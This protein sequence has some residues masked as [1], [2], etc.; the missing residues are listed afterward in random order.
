MK[1]LTMAKS[2]FKWKG[3]KMNKIKL[4]ALVGKSGAGK[5][6]VATELVKRADYYKVVSSTTRPPRVGEEDGVD[7]H[8][9]TKEEFA[10]GGFAESAKFNNWYYGTR[11]TDL[12]AN[13]INVGVFNPSGIYQLWE[14]Q[15]YIDLTVIYIVAEDKIRLKRQ[16]EREEN[17][18]VG[19]IVRRF[20]TDEEDFNQFD[21]WFDY[22]LLDKRKKNLSIYYNNGAN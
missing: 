10:E 11:W 2:Q 15:D 20:Q 21:E 6:F 8:F 3:R 7:Y 5:D 1:Y 16:L 12:K 18:N 13:K 9:L 17:P 14:L 22:Q 19:E 4:Y